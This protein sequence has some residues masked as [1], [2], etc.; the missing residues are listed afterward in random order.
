MPDWVL[1]GVVSG[2]A[3]LIWYLA[4]RIMTKQDVAESA[5]R[6]TDRNVNAKLDAIHSYM[7]SELRQFDVRLSV[8]ETLVLPNKPMR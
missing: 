8:V 7:Q 5:L 3:G 1:P 2:L 6:E 4:R